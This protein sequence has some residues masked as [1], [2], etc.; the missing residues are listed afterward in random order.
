MTKE[1]YVEFLKIATARGFMPMLAKERVCEVFKLAEF[2]EVTD[3][4]LDSAIF[5]LKRNY[6]VLHDPVIND[7][8]EILPLI[9][10]AKMVPV[11]IEQGKYWCN[12]S[13][14]HIADLSNE[15]EDTMV[16]TSID[17]PWCS[18][19]CRDEYYPPSRV[20]S[21]FDEFLEKSRRIKN[22]N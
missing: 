4:Q 6:Q 16:Q 17:N 2:D 12:G 18:D 14:H 8:G 7:D 20:N 11:K 21:K 22:E 19:D 3:E 1:K 13:K 10:D 9:Q 5:S 15:I